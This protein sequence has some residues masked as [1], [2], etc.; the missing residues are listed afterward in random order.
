MVIRDS[1]DPQ[2]H[3]LAPRL[4]LSL[5]SLRLRRNC[6]S[7]CQKLRALDRA[8]MIRYHQQSVF[9]TVLRSL[10]TYIRKAHLQY[11][12]H[13][14]KI[15]SI[16]DIIYK[17]IHHYTYLFI[18][19]GL[20]TTIPN[21]SWV[22]VT[23][24]NGFVA[25]HVAK[26]FL[27][28]GYKVRGTVRD[29]ERAPWLVDNVLKVYADRGEFELV[30]VQDLA[31][32]HAF[33]DAVK[34]VSAIAHVATIATLA[35]EP[36][37]VVPKTVAGAI[38]MMEAALK[39]PSVKELVYTSSIVAATMPFPGNDT[40][41]DRNTWNDAAVQLAWSPPPYDPSHGL[42]VYMAS[43][44][45]AEKAVW[46]FI[47]EKKPHFAVNSV[48]PSTIMGEPLN[49][50]H[51]KSRHFGVKQLLDGNVTALAGLPA[52]KYSALASTY[53]STFLS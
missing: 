33:D 43:K 21:G 7:I 36:K 9:F 44:V 34:G 10:D 2:P 27:E 8:D 15:G 49:K 39:E 40:H 6:I 26:Q 52:S 38:S 24:V 37:N 46:K 20:K 11:L 18:M 42:F 5:S 31:A 19:S 51:I 23:G 25:S 22:L 28:R 50:N 14:T 30:N 35:P 12:N 32:D 45:E 3:F 53:E 17:S 41:V 1:C 29:L 48:C 47:D 13:Q 16:N 4:A